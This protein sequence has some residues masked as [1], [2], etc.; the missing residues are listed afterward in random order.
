VPSVSNFFFAGL[1]PQFLGVYPKVIGDGTQDLLYS[2]RSGPQGLEA[3]HY[4]LGQ[5]HGDFPAPYRRF[6]QQLYHYTFQVSYMGMYI[7]CN[8]P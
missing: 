4:F 6:S 1:S 7:F 5:S 2:D 3:T 8:I